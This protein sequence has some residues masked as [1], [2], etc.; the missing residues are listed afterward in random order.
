MVQHGVRI[1]WARRSLNV[2][3]I[4]APAEG[5]SEVISTLPSLIVMVPETWL[6]HE[7]K[8]ADMLKVTM[9]RHLYGSLTTLRAQPMFISDLKEMNSV[10]KTPSKDTTP[11]VFLI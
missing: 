3:Q 5:P 4:V 10:I 11:K 9:P 7:N 6:M 8:T 1:S 2:P